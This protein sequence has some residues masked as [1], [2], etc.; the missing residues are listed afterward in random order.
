MEFN[1]NTIVAN[2]KQSAQ[3]LAKQ[4]PAGWIDPKW[5]LLFLKHLSDIINYLLTS[6]QT[7]INRSI[8]TLVEMIATLDP[9]NLNYSANRLTKAINATAN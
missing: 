1:I 4:S 9:D 7:E 6:N 2:L 5:N 3:N 8:L